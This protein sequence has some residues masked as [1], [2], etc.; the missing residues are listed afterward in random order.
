[1]MSASHVYSG[2]FKPQRPISDLNGVIYREESAK[3][4]DDAKTV[5]GDQLGCAWVGTT[6]IVRN[7]FQRTILLAILRKLARAGGHEFNSGD[8]KVNQ[9]IGTYTAPFTGTF[10][11]H[12]KTA[13]A[14]LVT[15]DTVNINNNWTWNDLATGWLNDLRASFNNTDVVYFLRC[16]IQFRNND[17]TN[18]NENVMASFTLPM[19][20][21]KLKFKVNNT[22]FI[23][24]R[25]NDSGG[26]DNVDT[27]DTNPLYG[28]IY[29]VN[30]S[31]IAT[32]QI[33]VYG[34]TSTAYGAPVGGW[35]TIDP[36]EWNEG[37]NRQ[38]WARPFDAKVLGR[39]NL[40]S[41]ITLQPG[42]IKKNK[43]SFQ[44]ELSFDKLFLKAF[45]PEV[46]Q[47]R[48]PFL[49]GK[50]QLVGLSKI[51]RTNP[52]LTEGP[53]IKLGCTSRWFM[54]AEAIPRRRMSF[55]GEN[56]QGQST[57]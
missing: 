48:Y 50:T 7:W 4:I 24:N 20:N 25:T 11:Y 2:R 42:E 56:V 5:G 12:W 10:I 23:Q 45:F 6:C 31:Q 33:T 28:K 18:N 41:N 3:E 49:Y 35:I 16:H 17:P 29:V 40:A 53:A 15:E 8:E 37:S 21:L 30:D 47:D 55:I 9:L 44:D 52:S 32:K 13:R 34:P 43:I 46:D 14:N 1:M 38:L 54:I 36:T 51:V 19:V 26:G 22:I 27:V 39:C 57:G